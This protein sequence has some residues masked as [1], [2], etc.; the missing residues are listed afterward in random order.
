VY[1]GTTGAKCQVVAL[2]A[3][4]GALLWSAPTGVD[5]ETLLTL[6]NGV[7]YAGSLVPTATA[8]DGIVYAFNGTSGALL[9]SYQTGDY[10]GNGESPLVVSNGVMY[11][12]SGDHNVY[13]LNAGTGSLQWS[14]LTGNPFLDA[15]TVIN[16]IVYI[17]SEDN[18]LYAV[19][20]SPARQPPA[21]GPTG[22]ERNGGGNLDEIARCPCTGKP[23]D[24]Y[25][26]NF[27]HS[28]SDLT[29]PG[30]GLPLA[31][32][33]TY[34]AGA[35]SQHGPLG[36]GWT[37][38]YNWSLAVD[39]SGNVTITQENGSTVAFA[40]NGS[41]GYTAPS[42][43]LATLVKNGDGTYTFMRQQSQDRYTFSATGQLTAETDR[44]GYTT[45]LA[46]N[47]SGQLATVTDPAGRALTLAYDG[48]GQITKVTDPG[49][50]SV[51]F[52]Y[53]GS[54]NL[55]SFTDVNGGVTSFTYDSNHRLLTMTDPRG[56]VVTNVYD[57]SGRVTKQT[58]ALGRATTFSY[59]PPDSN[60]NSSTMIT[61]PRGEVTLDHYYNGLLMSE[62]KGYG[63]AQ[64]ATWSYTYDPVSLG[65]ASITDPNGNVTSQTW[66][67]AGNVLSTTD[68]LGRVTTNTYDAQNDL[69]TITDPNGVTTTNTYDAHGNLLA[70]STPLVGNGQTYT[71]SYTYGDASHPGDVTA[72]TNAD[73]KTWTSTYDADG[74]RASTTDP[75]GD[76]T[77]D[78]YNVLGERTAETNPLGNTT[79]WTYDAFGDVMSVIDPL[80]HVTA[81][82]FDADGNQT[83][84]TDTDGH[85]TKY[86]Y[87]LDNEL[88]SVQRADGTT[89]DD[90]Y[91]ADG[92]QTQQSD[93][94]GHATT[95]AY[96]PLNRLI[97]VTDPLGRVTSSTYDG[98]GNRITETAPG[99]LVTTYGFDTANELVAITYSDGKTPAV[100]YA[101]DAD[102]RRV[103]MTDGT[104]T[105]TTTYDSLGRLTS[106]TDGA[107]N[108]VGYGDDLAGQL[109]SLTYPSGKAVTRGYDAAGRLTSVTDW[110]GHTSTFNYDK[111]GEL[112]RLV[113]ANH[114]VADLTYDR[115]GQALSERYTYESCTNPGCMSAWY[116]LLFFTYSYDPAGLLASATTSVQT[117]TQPQQTYG[118]TSLTQLA[119][120]ALTGGTTT[121]YAYDQADEP[122]QL[123]SAS[124]SEDVA[125]EV[126][127]LTQGAAST[128]YSDNSR[129][130]RTQ[131]AVSGGATVSY[132]YDE[133]NR[134]TSV[135]GIAA[136]TT[137][138]SY[139]GDGLRMSKT[140]GAASPERFVWD[141]AEGLPLLVVDGATS[142]ISG[143]GGLPL[144]QI[145]G[146]APLYYLH[147]QLGSTRALVDSTG[148]MLVA[149]YTYDAYG[150]TTATTGTAT[151]PLQYAGQYHDAETGLYYLRARYY[152]PATAQFLTRDPLASLSSQPYVYAG[153]DP[154]SATDL[155]GLWWSWRDI[156]RFAGVVGDVAAFAP[157]VGAV[158]GGVAGGVAGGVIGAALCGP[159]CAVIGAGVGG[160]SWGSW[161]LAAGAVIG[162]VA[163]GASDAASL[164]ADAEILR[165][166]QGGACGGAAQY[167]ADQG[168]L[169]SDLSWTSID[170]AT[171]G[172]DRIA[173]LRE[174]RDS[175]QIKA[176]LAHL[177]NL[178]KVKALL[179]LSGY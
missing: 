79:T 149:T 22:P 48:G 162:D 175:P 164:V 177:D 171:I 111:A 9:W 96:D 89:L 15:P 68:P 172:L 143:P 29:V 144:E 127:K 83:Q 146:A 150:A 167:Q 135:T 63:T 124:L 157:V 93:G 156:H 129:G 125:G 158:V 136:G 8:F 45:I 44:D 65:V 141:T 101:Y 140:V 152:D 103:S 174:L 49:G 52:S 71:T 165:G 161:G 55:Q 95:Y 119:S 40:P 163:T 90:A 113:Y 74:D 57:S 59:T 138:Y 137:T 54:G 77:S 80:G 179:G 128:S 18:Y 47:G 67:A 11:F 84:V 31:F 105:T 3:A 102:G 147:D 5:Q 1:I 4:S 160:A 2:N 91:D 115:A 106:E 33:H 69:L 126:T 87:D 56:G 81:S 43:V 133:A 30:R 51:A 78:T 153:D 61:D 132:G 120:V 13:A 20:A 72:T 36:F 14:Y 142:Y 134:L 88:T 118:Y 173:R 139:N 23:V 35:A 34:N 25:S 116:P 159:A 166:D 98:S 108:V 100:S 123:G 110:L 112:S 62:T 70:T 12:G 58:D 66:D 94:L 154:L 10:G 46:Y 42:R 104:G 19:E 60:G 75:L 109:T 37:D 122:T 17:G 6:N 41:G 92:N 86:S 53:D 117:T 21:Q 85:V 27:T 32:S 64:A 170:V 155:S 50:R 145:T 107:G 39:G 16:G 148:V 114:V 82:Q 121:S 178:G 28:F 76:K 168:Q 176:L 131:M 38:S 26:G 99:S 7:V 151:T 24:N 169:E 97:S 73:G 130:D